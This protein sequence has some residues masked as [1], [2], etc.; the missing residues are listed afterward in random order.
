MERVSEPIDSS[1]TVSQQIVSVDQSNGNGDGWN[2]FIPLNERE[3][4]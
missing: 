3:L 2:L 4:Q 1:K